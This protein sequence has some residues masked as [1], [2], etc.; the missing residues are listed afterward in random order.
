MQY[1]SVPSVQRG[2]SRS[3]VHETTHDRWHTAIHG[4]A[5]VDEERG[6]CLGGAAVISTIGDKIHPFLVV[7]HGNFSGKVGLSL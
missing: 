7:L 3:T 6:I 2:V 1:V 5:M 4:M